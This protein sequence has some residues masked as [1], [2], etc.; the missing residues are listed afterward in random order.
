MGDSELEDF[1][2]AGNDN[3]LNSEEEEEEF[4]TPNKVPINILV[5]F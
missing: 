4:I 3:N 1:N 5:L 2:D